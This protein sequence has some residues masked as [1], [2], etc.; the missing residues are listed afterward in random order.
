MAYVFA[1]VELYEETLLSVFWFS[2]LISLLEGDSL[3]CLEPESI[4]V[5]ELL[6]AE[7]FVRSCSSFSRWSRSN[8]EGEEFAMFIFWKF[9]VVFRLSLKRF[10][11]AALFVKLLLGK[12]PSWLLCWLLPGWLGDEELL[13]YICDFSIFF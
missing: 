8:S 10:C 3:A 4:R 7:A 12:L 13:P 6:A 9:D 11:I 2:I 5:V 1:P